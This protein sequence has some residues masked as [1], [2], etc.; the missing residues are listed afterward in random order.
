MRSRCGF[1]WWTMPSAA[2]PA[3]GEPAAPNP[4]YTLMTWSLKAWRR[5]RILEK[6]TLDESAWRR[7][8]EGVPCLSRLS[9]EERRR[10]RDLA[11]LFLHEKQ[12]NGA[13]DVVPTE[14]MRLAIA[15]QA[16]L[17]IL[18]L[19][20]DYYRGWVEVIVYPDMFL[21]RRE[22]VDEAGVVHSG[23]AALSGESW[24][25]GPVILSWADVE[26]AGQGG[27]N[28]VL[29]E[30]AHKID[31][32]NGDAN[33]FP[34]LHAGMDRAEWKRDFEAAYDDFCARVDR[35][36]YTVIDPYAA[37]QPAEF[38]AVLTEAFF[39]MPGELK[40]QYS[41]VYRQLAR[42]YRQ[43]PAAREVQAVPRR[44]LFSL[45]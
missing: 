33:G 37:E 12:V 8:C 44:T 32:L 40:S 10:L 29:H 4:L 35:G 31:M 2:K 1:R 42:F 19:D 27:V 6:A 26:E 34:P 18:N 21:A 41:A 3:D 5:R 22:F 24:P 16:C 38:F 28:V 15:A 30:F 39:E 36:E 25:N 14:D 7:V 11:I 45:S 23:R 20:L 17:L 43:D 9:A 13:H